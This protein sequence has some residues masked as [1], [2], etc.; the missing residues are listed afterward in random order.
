MYIYMDRYHGQVCRAVLAPLLRFHQR[1][2]LEAAAESVEACFTEAAARVGGVLPATSSPPPS[3]SQASIKDASKQGRQ[4]RRKELDI[5]KHPR[6]MALNGVDGRQGGKDSAG[7]APEAPVPSRKVF[8]E[9]VSW[10]LA[11]AVIR[12]LR[13]FRVAAAGTEVAA[14]P[15]KLGYTPTIKVLRDGTVTVDESPRLV[16]LA[17]LRLAGAV[18]TSPGPA[19]ALL[20]AGVFHVL[21]RLPSDP[22]A[23]PA[24]IAFALG[25]LCQG[26][27]HAEI[28]RVFATKLETDEADSGGAGSSGKESSTQQ[29]GYE[30]CASVLTQQVRG[31][32]NGWLCGRALG[33]FCREELDTVQIPREGGRVLVHDSSL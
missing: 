15:D 13:G 2:A 6:A 26:V 29:G 25:A 7:A 17:G 21:W 20:E 28:L 16:A 19:R 5:E 14:V 27:R 9:D 4:E 12:S 30:A 31:E 11:T 23:T 24:G 3:S 33:G 1:K 18:A 10:R 32:A 22:A 8:D